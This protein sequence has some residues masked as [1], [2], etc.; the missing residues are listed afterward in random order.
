MV[1]L[2]LYVMHEHLI[3]RR[4]TAA[5]RKIADCSAMASTLAEINRRKGIK[6]AAKAHHDRF[7]AGVFSNMHQILKME[8]QAKNA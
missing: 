7:V 3:R 6:P 2:I 4:P 8:A 5:E 1:S